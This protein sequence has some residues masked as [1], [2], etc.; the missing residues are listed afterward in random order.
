VNPDGTTPDLASIVAVTAQHFPSGG[1][2][3]GRP[4]LGVSRYRIFMTVV[5][6]C[7]VLVDYWADQSLSAHLSGDIIGPISVIIWALTLL[8]AF[9]VGPAGRLRDVMGW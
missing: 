6:C 1:G 8:G 4:F 7:V 2:R 9:R 3:P 5:F